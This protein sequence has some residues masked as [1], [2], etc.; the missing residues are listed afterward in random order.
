MQADSSDNKITCGDNMVVLIGEH[1]CFTEKK[2]KWIELK[3]NFYNRQNFGKSFSEHAPYFITAKL[4]QNQRWSPSRN[5]RLPVFH[6]IAVIEK[7]C[8]IQRAA[9]KKN[10]K[11][12][13]HTL[14]IRVSFP[15]FRSFFTISVYLSKCRW[16]TE[17]LLREMV[18]LF[19]GAIQNKMTYSYIFIYLKW[20]ETG[21]DIV[22][23]SDLRIDLHFMEI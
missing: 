20:E 12:W 16:P 17:N 1:C 4:T 21:T 2:N 10:S 18:S 15:N 14:G 13:L 9:V 5:S 23:C 3:R 22:T 8:K 11:M 6:K 19:L 7:F